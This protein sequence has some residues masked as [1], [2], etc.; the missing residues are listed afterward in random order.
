MVRGV[1]AGVVE[2]AEPAIRSD[3]DVY[4]ED[5]RLLYIGGECGEEDL[6]PPFFLHV[7]PVNEDDMPAALRRHG[8]DN[9]DFQ[10]E[11]SRLPLD[12]NFKDVP[13]LS[14]VGCAALVELP[15]YE[16]ARIRT[17]QF[18]SGGPRLWHGEFEVGGGNAP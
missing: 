2:R 1:G 11:A 4:Y 18:V 13:A 17:G 12:S 5:N 3:F 8:F 16:V 10:F 7:F 15:G 14:S 9:L 6:E